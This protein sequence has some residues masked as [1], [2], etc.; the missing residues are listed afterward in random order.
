MMTSLTIGLV[1]LIIVAI[2]FLLLPM[3]KSKIKPSKWPAMVAI[4]LLSGISIG[5]YSYWGASQG[6]RHRQAFNEIDDF[7]AEF[8]NNKNQTKEQ[9]LNNLSTLEDKV[10]YS[11]AALARL[12]NVYLELGMHDKA[13]DCFVKAQSM[14][15]EIVDYQ[16]QAIYSYS[17]GNQGQLP[18]ELR[19]QAQTLLALYPQNFV[20]MNL[21]A[22]D[23]YFQGEYADAMLYWQKLI[24]YDQSLTPERKTVIENA[25]AKAKQLAPE[26][27]VA[28]IVVKVTV[29]LDKQLAEKVSP[30]DVVYIY[31]KSPEQRMPLA[32]QKRMAHELPITVELTNQQQ[33]LPNMG[34]KAGEKVEVFAKVTASGDPLTKEGTLRG[35]SQPLVVN[36]GINPVAICIN[37]S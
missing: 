13:I 31:V 12:G 29:S 14:A 33:M 37:Q 15:P 7:F 25:I 27:K 2:G 21:L 19:L 3:A 34:M 16:V 32:V 9:V 35:E 8:A 17:L 23:Y 24:D 36:Y 6:L 22:L 20:L 30:T 28:N 26:L 5:L 4:L 1:V 18:Q 10:A 11:H